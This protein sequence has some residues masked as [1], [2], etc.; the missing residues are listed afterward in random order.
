MKDMPDNNM[1]AIENH[2]KSDVYFP[3]NPETT[4]IDRDKDP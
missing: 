4:S 1:I 2:I 3:F